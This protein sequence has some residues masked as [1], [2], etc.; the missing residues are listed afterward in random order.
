[1]KMYEKTVLRVSHIEENTDLLEP[2]RRFV[3]FSPT[4]ASRE[5]CENV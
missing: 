5:V 4:D 2:Y 3:I 1:M